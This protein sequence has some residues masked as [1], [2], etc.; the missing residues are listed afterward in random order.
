MKLIKVVETPKHGAIDEERYEPDR[1][2][3]FFEF[4]SYTVPSVVYRVDMDTYDISVFFEP[5]T[6]NADLSHIKTDY[7]WYDS[8]DGTKVPLTILRNSKSWP[9]LD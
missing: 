3:L 6:F 2:E 5:K 7:I 4:T 9:S 1:K 8:F